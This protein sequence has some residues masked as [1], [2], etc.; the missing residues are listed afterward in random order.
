MAQLPGRPC[1]NCGAPVAAGQRFCTNCGAVLEAQSS[2]TPPSQYGGPPQQSY[3]QVQQVPPYAQQQVPPYAQQQQIPPYAQQQ[4][5][6]SPI[7]EALGALGLLFL[8][9][10]YRRGYVPRRQSSGCC[11]CLVLLVI[12]LIIFGIPAF[13]VVRSSTKVLNFNTGN[14]SN[15]SLTTQP[16]ITTAQINQ[17]VPYA[18]VNITVVS[19][20]QS[21][22]FLDDNFS[23]TNGMVRLNIKENNNNTSGGSY[24]YG[25]VARLVLPDQ[26]TAA[27]VNEQ[28]SLGPNAGTTRTNWL[29][30]QVPTS[31]KI[32]QLTLRLGKDSESQV[33]IPLTGKAD[34]SQYQPKT[35]NPNVKTQYAGLTWTVTSATTALSFRGQQA[36]KGMR[37]VAVTLK[38]DNPTATGFNA[39][40]GDY[41]RLQ[42]GGATTAPSA[43]S[44]LPLSFPAGSSGAT[45]NVVFL[46]PDSS[47]SY[48]LILLARPNLSPPISQ[49]TANFRV[50]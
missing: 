38:V 8:L 49:A 31:V 15:S 50:G 5:Q 29:D 45:G 36:D 47:N 44:T 37:Y 10:R 43:D 9:R 33:N 14:N 6:N 41:I 16:P 13:V 19:V 22:A 20:E 27:P 46:M 26:N 12:F 30:F 28:Q 3:P 25:D 35:A 32:D 2:P 7:A 18:G 11:G 21:Q 48:T 4:Q 1:P 24:Y 23:G 34:L 42:S 17:T 40:W 39:Y